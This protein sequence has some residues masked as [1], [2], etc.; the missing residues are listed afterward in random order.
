M[1]LSPAPRD[2]RYF[3]ELLR[4]GAVGLAA[5]PGQASAAETLSGDSGI[6]VPLIAVA[7]LAL[8]GLAANELFNGRLAWRPS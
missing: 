7:L 3:E 1:G 5:K 8:L 2:R 4:P 6:S